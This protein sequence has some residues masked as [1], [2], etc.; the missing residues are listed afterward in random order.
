M[1]DTSEEPLYSEV[2]PRYEGHAALVVDDGTLPRRILARLLGDLGF[3]E[4]LV[5]STGQEALAIAQQAAPDVAFVDW[6]MPDFAGPALLDSL[7]VAHPSTKLL[8]LSNCDDGAREALAAGADA[9]LCKPAAP[10]LVR[11]KLALLDDR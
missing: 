8:V 1:D 9:V 7:R 3:G 5:A 2:A 4:V 6:H 11:A 10:D